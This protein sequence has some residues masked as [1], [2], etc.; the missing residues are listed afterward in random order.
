MFQNV[1]DGIT[2]LV[3]LASFIMVSGFIMILSDNPKWISRG[4]AQISLA[5]YIIL[6]SILV[7]LSSKS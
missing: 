6:V 3:M 4:A 5:I 7:V 2:I 1:S